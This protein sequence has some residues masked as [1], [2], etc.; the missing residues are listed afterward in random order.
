MPAVITLERP[1]YRCEDCGCEFRPMSGKS[2]ERCMQ[3]F[4]K[5][6][7]IKMVVDIAP[8]LAQRKEV[9]P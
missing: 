7:K 9:K 6:T 5:S 2:P 1:W 3:W 8:E 4:C